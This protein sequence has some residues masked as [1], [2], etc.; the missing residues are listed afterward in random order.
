MDQINH[1][2]DLLPDWTQSIQVLPA[3]DARSVPVLRDSD[4][5]TDGRHARLE[6]L[7][8]CYESVR[9]AVDRVADRLGPK[10][11]GVEDVRRDFSQCWVGE[12]SADGPRG[13]LPEILVVLEAPPD[14]GEDSP[15]PGTSAWVRA[16]AFGVIIT[17]CSRCRL[18]GDCA[19]RTRHDTAARRCAPWWRRTGSSCVESPCSSWLA[20]C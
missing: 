1:R 13:Q 16:C 9:A 2:R 18:G 7:E 3:H 5:D 15:V 8:V 17:C 19:T 12:E 14:L 20:S 4:G 10:R 11:D 6:R